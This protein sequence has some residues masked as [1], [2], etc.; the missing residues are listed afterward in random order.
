MLFGFSG[1]LVYNVPTNMD[2]KG[3]IENTY[4][5]WSLDIKNQKAYTGKTLTGET[6]Q[7]VCLYS[8]TTQN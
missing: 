8:R 5:L 3:R 2:R 1:T 6:F 7:G 4:V